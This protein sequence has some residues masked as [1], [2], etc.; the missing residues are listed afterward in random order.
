MENGAAERLDL[1]NTNIR[2]IPRI[3]AEDFKLEA[4]GDGRLAYAVITR[5]QAEFNFQT[6]G[7]QIPP[8]PAEDSRSTL[9][10]LD[11]PGQRDPAERNP[12]A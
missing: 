7:N 8:P 2:S 4:L 11:A 3:I 6:A 1:T 12:K 5:Q 10:R 9:V